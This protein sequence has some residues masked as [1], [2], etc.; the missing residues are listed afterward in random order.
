MAIIMPIIFMDVTGFPKMQS[1]TP[2]TNI[3]LEAFAIAY[4]NGVTI[5]ITLNA[6]MF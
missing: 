6:T 1:D 4:V 5:D 2:M 3:L